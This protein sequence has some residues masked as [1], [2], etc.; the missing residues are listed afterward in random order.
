MSN[1][2]CVLM[3]HF[4]PRVNHISM[5]HSHRVY[6]L[7]IVVLPRCK[8]R[9]LFRWLVETPS[10]DNH[11]YRMLN[12]V[13]YFVTFSTSCPLYLDVGLTTVHHVYCYS[14]KAVKCPNTRYLIAL[15]HRTALNISIHI[16][17]VCSQWVCL[18]RGRLCSYKKMS[19]S[20]G[21]DI[22]ITLDNLR[23]APHCCHGS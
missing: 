11:H 15:I 4:Q 23:T 21:V 3:Q 20:R 1:S 10:L 2:G 6:N 12:R 5:S 16:R 19:V 22:L 8:K 13:Q 17:G 18:S 14:P 9:Q 7:Y